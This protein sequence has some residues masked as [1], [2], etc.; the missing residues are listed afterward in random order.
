M[1]IVPHDMIEY[2][3]FFEKSKIFESIWDVFCSK[4]DTTS[5][6]TFSD[7]HEHVWKHTITKC[8]ELLLKFYKNSFTYSDIDIKCFNERRNINA[9]VTTLYNAMHHCF[10]LLVS[11]LPNPMQWIPQAVKSITMY[12]DFVRHMQTNKSTMQINAAQLC[13]Q[14]KDVLRL[15]GDF[16]SVNNLNTQVCINCNIV[17]LLLQ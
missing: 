13:L 4:L 9:H 12:L 16:S 6:A 8:K 3:I 7:I 1:D 15:K 2:F 10:N 17:L 11:S 5:I 14:M